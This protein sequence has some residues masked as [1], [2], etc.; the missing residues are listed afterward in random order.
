MEEMQQTS[1]LATKLSKIVT[2][3]PILKNDYIIGIVMINI[4]YQVVI[5]FF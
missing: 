1:S 3:L 4:F 2:K 5:E